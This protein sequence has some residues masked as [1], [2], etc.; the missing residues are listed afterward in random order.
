MLYEE[1]VKYIHSLKRFSD[2]APFEN[3]KA[4]LKKFNN[5]QNGLKVIHIAG[6]NGKGSTAAMLS[7]VFIGAGYKTGLF[8]SPFIIDFTERIQINGEFINRQDLA[9][10]CE[11]VKRTDIELT[12]FDFITAMALIYYKEK[13]CDIV[14][15]ETGL[16]GRLDATNVT[17]EKLGCIITKIGLD[18]TAVL[19]DTIEEIT[20]EK[21]GII[22]NTKPVAT[23]PFQD[24][25]VYP[26]IKRFTNNLLVAD[27]KSEIIK[28]DYSGNSFMYNGKRYETSLIGKHQIENAITVIELLDNLNLGITY[29]EIKNGIKNTTFPAR[30]EIVSE[31]PLVIL[32]GAHNPDGAKALKSALSGLKD[33]TAII[34][35]MADKDYESVLKEVLKDCALAVAVTPENLPRALSADKLC[36]VAANYC[37]S[38]KAN[39]Y[40]DA[41]KKALSKGSKAVVV[42]GSLYLASGIRPYLKEYFKK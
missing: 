30:L 29:E 20:A 1:A 17:E 24:K 19:G 35:V 16:G 32:D 6:T 31:N 8:V 41:V 25:R 33:F 10:L 14:I 4:V 23:S 26:V 42:F 5:P 39:N 27:K 38:V 9:D 7:N 36:K 22:K 37:K 18:H 15:L 34:G 11:R 13:N 2:N 40:E 12:E 21:C 28:S 3:L